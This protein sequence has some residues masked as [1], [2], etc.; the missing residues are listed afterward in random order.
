M[1]EPELVVVAGSLARNAKPRV[2]RAQDAIAKR[3]RMGAASEPEVERSKDV[4][5]LLD[6]WIRRLEREAGAES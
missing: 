5:S 4:I 6:G 2:T 1:A 3:W